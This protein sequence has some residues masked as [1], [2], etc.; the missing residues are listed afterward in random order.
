[1]DTYKG[2]PFELLE[3]D[4]DRRGRVWSGVFW[5][6]GDRYV[7]SA[8]Y[9]WPETALERV[10]NSIDTRLERISKGGQNND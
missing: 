7:M 4:L 3:I 6:N 8:V 2:V 10:K 1:M 5:I 9:Q